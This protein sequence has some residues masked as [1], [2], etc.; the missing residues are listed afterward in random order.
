M[1]H[2]WAK[3]AGLRGY[4]VA[5]SSTLYLPEV[6]RLGRKGGAW[7]VSSGFKTRNDAITQ[8]LKQQ[9][10]P[11]VILTGYYHAYLG[12]TLRLQDGVH[13]ERSEILYQG[14]KRAISNAQQA[15]DQVVLLLDVPELKQVPADCQ[16]RAEILGRN[17]SCEFSKQS[18]AK[19]AA[20]FNRIVQ[21]LKYDF[22]K[23]KLIDPK[24][25]LCR[26]DRCKSSV[27]GLPIYRNKDDDHLSYQGSQALGQ[28]YLAE[29][30]N[31]LQ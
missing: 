30:G 23:L 11:M 3:D 14:L 9:H 12:T 29:L 20:E 18:E 8:H 1:L 5:Q 28:A 15:S 26:A 6:E 4:D 25:V 31:P 13:R 22:P 27:N 17:L 21:Q 10:Y 16:M 24:Q 2:I 19:V 7:Q